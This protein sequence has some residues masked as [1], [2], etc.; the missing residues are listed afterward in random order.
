MDSASQATTGVR[1]RTR[2]AILEAARR[3]LPGNP[4]ASIFEIAASAGVGRATVHRHFRDR[5]EL[6]L[7]LAR[8]VY[9]LS[10]EAVA[11]ARPEAGPPLAA[12]RRIIEEQL[13]LGAALD[14]VYNERTF[15]KHP[16]YFAHLTYGEEQVS[17]AIRAAAGDD[18]TLPSQW[19]ERAFWTLL[20]LGSDMVSEGMAR[21]VAVDSIMSTV[22]NGIVKGE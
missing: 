13:D 10:D 5:E 12:L 3:M 2:F 20:R 6:I 7:E 9:Q 16:E 19:R 14:F 21:H 1:A 22:V 15:F 11:R 8:H 17:A 4:S 18:Q